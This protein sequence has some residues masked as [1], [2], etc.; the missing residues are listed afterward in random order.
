LLIDLRE[1]SLLWEASFLRKV[2]LNYIGKLALPLN[3][4]KAAS[5]VHGNS[6]WL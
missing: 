6:I 3:K 2:I 5:V 1:P 4:K